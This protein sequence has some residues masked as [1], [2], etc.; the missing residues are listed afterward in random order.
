MSLVLVDHSTLASRFQHKWLPALRPWSIWSEFEDQQS[1]GP[2][3]F[4]H[5]CPQELL[6]L[7][8]LVQSLLDQIRAS[9]NPHLLGFCKTYMLRTARR[10][11]PLL[12]N[13]NVGLPRR[14][15]R[16]IFETNTTASNLAGD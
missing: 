9:L 10:T 16:N 13:Q 7:P 8:A 6:K 12:Q 1:D 5:Y 15:V 2:N 14:G 11:F 3:G 4:N